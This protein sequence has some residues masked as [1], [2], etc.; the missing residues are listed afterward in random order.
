[1]KVV[2]IGAGVAG[3]AIGWR[4]LQ[5]GAE[6]TILE[7]AQPAHA[8]TW[9]AAGMIGVTAELGEAQEHEI[10]FAKHSNSLW[11]DFA[12][13]IEA[14]SSRSIF[15]RQD[16]A[17]M[18]AANADELA[19]FT[20]RAAADPSLRIL[21]PAATRALAPMLTGEYAGALWAETEAH[22]DSRALGAALSIAFQ[23]TGGRLETNQAVVRIESDGHRAI[24]A[25][26]AH[27][28]FEA[29]AFVIAAGAWSGQIAPGLPRVEPVKGEMILL[30]PPPG[31]APPG[32][33]VWGNGV[34]LVP[35]G[36]HLLVGATVEKAGFDTGLTAKAAERLLTRA[37]GLMPDL[38][39]WR[40][41]DHWAGLR[42]RSADG[43]PLLGP[44]GT[45]GLY[46]A[47][48]QYRNG[49]LFAPA[50]AELL[51]AM[52]LGKAEP[53]PAFDP[54]REGA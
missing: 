31:V 13:E 50:I 37:L 26:A 49:I 5:A 12:T 46:L 52:V 43:L 51:C 28:L 2:V 17:L 40:L 23:R 4:L 19:A 16:G 32:P 34:Y 44:T 39:K 33:V 14:V 54:R 41:A 11:P 20:A 8:A 25:R 15:Y 36:G 3:L 22:V 18:V 35:R 7:S 30:T 24:A 6:V 1:M 21:D 45:P 47:S 53:I 9:A 10:Q 27:G 48:G 42:P 38:A 29:D